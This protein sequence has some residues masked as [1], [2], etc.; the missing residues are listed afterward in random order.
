MKLFRLVSVLTSIV[1]CLSIFTG[2]TIVG[3]EDISETESNVESSVVEDL[4]DESFIDE[5][6]SLSIDEAEYYRVAIDD[7]TTYNINNHTVKAGNSI[8]SKDTFYL[9]KGDNF[10]I[11]L[12][13]TPVSDTEQVQIGIL[14]KGTNTFYNFKKTT[15][16]IK[17]YIDIT[18]SGTYVFKLKNCTSN[19]IKV[20]GTFTPIFYT[21]SVDVPLIGQTYS[22]WCWA[23]C[24]E[25]SANALGYDDYTQADIVH[26]LKGTDD[27]PY[28]N[29]TGKNDDYR[30]GIEYATSNNYTATV[31]SSTY[32]IADMNKIL[33]SSKPL[34]IAW[35]KYSNGV[36]TGGHA[37]VLMAVDTK[38]Y[39]IKIQDPLNGG[40]TKKMQ[41]SE[42]TSNSLKKYDKSITITLK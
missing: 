14:N 17:A 33:A 36:R 12:S 13:Y 10:Y 9:R 37:N 31:S 6:A 19:D 27:E 39:Y 29:V 26:K 41:Y 40:S 25:M 4:A 22:N 5:P 28:P 34:M 21:S 38:T 24:I 18:A 7:Y 20:T 8:S 23:A 3:A 32:N 1:V 16:S 35:G 2:T 42:L 30:K 11:E 15:G